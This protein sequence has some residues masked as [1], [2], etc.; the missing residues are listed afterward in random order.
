MRPPSQTDN[1]KSSV[2][3]LDPVRQWIVQLSLGHIL[4]RTVQRPVW[5]LIVFI[6][7]LDARLMGAAHSCSHWLQMCA[8]VWSRARMEREGECAHRMSRK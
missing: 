6:A 2:G 3:G 7:Q 5:R 8:N 4:L 1:T